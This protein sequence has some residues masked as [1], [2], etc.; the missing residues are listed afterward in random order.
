MTN[1]GSSLL[2]ASCSMD[3]A[4]TSTSASAAISGRPAASAS[5]AAATQDCFSAS[6]AAAAGYT[7]LLSRYR[8]EQTL[9]HLHGFQDPR[10]L[11]AL[12]FNSAAGAAAGNHHQSQV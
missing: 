11:A 10:A 8:L 4:T 2:I 7:D 9:R 5:A 12:P 6:S 3:T 1:F